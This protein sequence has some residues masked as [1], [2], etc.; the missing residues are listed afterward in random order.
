MVTPDEHRSVME[1]VLHLVGDPADGTGEIEKMLKAN[2]IQNI[3]DIVNLQ[4][5]IVNTF[6]YKDGKGEM[7]LSKGHQTRLVIL[8]HFNKSKRN[9]GTSFPVLD[10]LKVDQD[11]FDT[12]RL[13]YDE[14]TYS[15]PC[16]VS[17]HNITENQNPSYN[18]S[19]GTAAP[20]ANTTDTFL[21]HDTL[22]QLDNLHQHDNLWQPVVWEGLFFFI[23]K[24]IVKHKY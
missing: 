4:R 6:T 10:W 21:T 11:E 3:L 24:K 18:I 1:H 16:I 2:G 12:F 9:S 13:D 22:Q 23:K 5:S 19:G 8:T 20:Q 14:N 17:D 15:I 7:E